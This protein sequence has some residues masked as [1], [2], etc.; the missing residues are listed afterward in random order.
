M[1]APGRVGVIADDPLQGHLL[2]AA[3]KGQGYQVVVCTDPDSL[4]PRW[5]GDNALDLWVVDLS[6]EDR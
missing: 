4:E 1:A 5:L 6:R 2:A 3:I